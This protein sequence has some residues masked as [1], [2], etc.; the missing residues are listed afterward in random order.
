M[1]RRARN[2]IR[3]IHKIVYIYLCML[4]L[5]DEGRI[6]VKIKKKKKQTL[7]FQKYCIYE[8]SV[9]LSFLRENIIFSIYKNFSEYAQFFYLVRANF[10]LPPEI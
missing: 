1:K 5:F 7:I 8:Y 9:S 2:W 3:A 4:S 10:L 6:S